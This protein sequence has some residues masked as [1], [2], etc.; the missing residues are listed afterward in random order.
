M[1]VEYGHIYY[2]RYKKGLVWL[3]IFCDSKRGTVVII[4]ALVSLM[5]FFSYFVVKKCF[6]ESLIVTELVRSFINEKGT[7]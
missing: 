6:D 5:S 4:S 2:D 1:G 3:Y 7:C